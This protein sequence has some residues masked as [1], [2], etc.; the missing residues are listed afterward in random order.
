MHHYLDMFWE[1]HRQQVLQLRQ[2]IDPKRSAISAIHFPEARGFDGADSL[3]AQADGRW[4]H[5]NTHEAAYDPVFMVP[6]TLQA[7]ALAL[8]QLCCSSCMAIA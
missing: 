8:Q 3:P 2:G 6:F 7:S 5:G 1:V 4:A